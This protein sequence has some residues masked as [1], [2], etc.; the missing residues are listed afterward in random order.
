MART[1]R[2]HAFGL[3]AQTRYTLETLEPA[4]SFT[5]ED[6]W[7]R[8]C[9]VDTNHDFTLK[10]TF[11]PDD[12]RKDFCDGWVFWN[13]WADQTDEG[14]KTVLC[15]DP[16]TA[17]MFGLPNIRSFIKGEWV[18]D[19]VTGIGSLVP[20]DDDTDFDLD[21][22]MMYASSYFAQD[23]GLCWENVNECVLARKVHTS[24]EN[25]PDRDWIGSNRAPSLGDAERIRKLYKWEG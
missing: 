5:D 14:I 9:T 19:R 11:I 17:D 21:S 23:Q 2:Q 16:T 13:S 18:T 10:L 24:D 6:V 3:R 1:N 20:Y 8:L 12:V 25:G 7:H 22:A 15:S 4:A